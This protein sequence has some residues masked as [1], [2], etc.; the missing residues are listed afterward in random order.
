MTDDPFASPEIE[1][2]WGYIA[3]SLDRLVEVGGSLDP[4]GLRTGARS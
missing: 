4:D 3:N 1:T 2:F